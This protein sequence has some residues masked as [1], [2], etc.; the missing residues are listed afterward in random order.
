MGKFL[1]F[2]RS[3]WKEHIADVCPPELEEEEFSE[4]YR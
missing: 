2:L 4:K 1:N 3:W